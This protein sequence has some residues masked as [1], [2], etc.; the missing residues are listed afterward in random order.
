MPGYV[1]KRLMEASM[2]RSFSIAVLM[3]VVVV[4]SAMPGRA[5]SPIRWLGEDPRDTVERYALILFEYDSASP[6]P[7]NER[8][9]RE[10]VYRGIRPTSEVTV[11]GHADS[12]GES[13][14]NLVL[15]KAR[16]ENVA[17]QI[18]RDVARYALLKAIGVGESIIYRGDF[19]EVRF[20][21]RTVQISI[22]TPA[23]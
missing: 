10:N 20:Y 23:R 11:V 12:L 13:Q 8:I 19:P 22:R 18:R 14:H 15:S 3:I 4:T 1:R 5:A 2:R 21:N 7:V 9:L 6:G 16:A 17:G